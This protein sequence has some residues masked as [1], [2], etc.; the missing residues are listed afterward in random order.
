ML[1][2]TVPE[3]LAYEKRIIASGVSADELMERAGKGMAESLRRNFPGKRKALILCGKGN[4]AGDAL[5]VAR[6]LVFG[7]G[8][9]AS[10]TWDVLVRWLKPPAHLG[11]LAAIKLQAL[12]SAESHFIPGSHLDIAEDP[13]VD[14]EDWPDSEGIVIDALLGIGSSGA[15]REDLA[16]LLEEAEEQRLALMFSTVALDIPTGLVATAAAMEADDSLYPED[17]SPSFVAT[18][19]LTVGWPKDIL[20]REEM[21]KWVG[22]IEVISIFDKEHEPTEADAASLQCGESLITALDGA[23]AC[24]RRESTSYKGD[25]GR[26]LIIGG[27]PGMSGAPI[28]SALAALYGGAGLVNV[29]VHPAVLQSVA[30]H[31][32]P[33]VMLSAWPVEGEEHGEQDGEEWDRLCASATV[34][35]L[36]PGL[37]KSPDAEAILEKVIL[38]TSQALVLDASA[39]TCLASR[40]DLLTDLHGRTVLTPHLGE[41]R[42][43]MGETSLPTRERTDA[44]RNFAR[45]HGVIVVLKGLRTIVADPV[46]H[47]PEDAGSQDEVIPCGE[48][49]EVHVS[50]NSSGNPALAVGGSGDTL[51]GLIAALIAQG[52]FLEAATRGAVWLHGHAADIVARQR[53]CEVGIRASEISAAFP[54]AIASARKLS[55]GPF[56]R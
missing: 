22:R 5:V 4:N 47:E 18:L 44:A 28:L 10:E 35:A 1:I 15:P 27:S 53:G 14:E 51:T 30:A 3:M 39:L 41:M 8:T 46:W 37:G 54:L 23:I 55:G 11:E 31:A 21:G 24:P 13:G 16:Q 45:K 34:I 33:E 49:D 36:G 29:A 17:V 7:R 43:L 50:W 25:F 52:N 38:S 48:P 9:P 19:T 40:P 42:R 26:V 6:E 12:R 56:M 20:V 2:L 32:P